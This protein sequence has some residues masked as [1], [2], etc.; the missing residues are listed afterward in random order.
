MTDSQNK[1]LL[2]GSALLKVVCKLKPLLH[3]PKQVWKNW[4][5]FFGS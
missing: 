1:K 5:A 3:Y 2:K 4:P